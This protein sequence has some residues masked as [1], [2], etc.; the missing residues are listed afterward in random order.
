MSRRTDQA[1]S[2]AA[3]EAEKAASEA[4]RVLQSRRQETKPEKLEL[5]AEEAPSRGPMLATSRNARREDVLDEIRAKR[6]EPVEVEPKPESKAETPKEEP[7]EEV[8]AA[9]EAP[10]V[11][12][13]E[14]PPVEAVPE[15]PKLVK[16]K[17][18][19]EEYEVSQSEIDDA[20]GERAWRIAKAQENRLKKINEAAT[21]SRQREE[22]IAK[23]AEVLLQQQQPRAAPQ[24]SNA[25]FIKSK[26]DLIRFGTPEESA[27]ALEAILQKAHKPVDQN[28]ILANAVMVI[29]ARQAHS[30]FRT[31]YSEIA[32]NPLLNDLF[33]MK[34]N[35]E[36][37]LLRQSGKPIDWWGVYSKI[38]NQIRSVVPARQSQPPTTS[39]TAG[40]PSQVSDKEARKASI[41][42][43]PTASARA[44][45]PKEEKP[46]TREDSL[47][48]MRR[49]RGLQPL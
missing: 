43:L 17:V 26:V 24:P 12:A 6:G 39:A 2:R 36:I 35:Q 46:E 18:D 21:E 47:N 38:G 11:E 29:E 14:A 27:A 44:E 34:A 37:A 10:K 25:E 20:G 41:T 45:L 8:Q 15:A 31:D 48:R 13:T 23:L 16:Q 3:A 28:A 42:V 9:P 7:K 40:N 19:G 30:K 33:T 22:R 49:S 1:A 32:S 5:K 4:A